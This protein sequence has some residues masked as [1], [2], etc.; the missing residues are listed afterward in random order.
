MSDPSPE[1]SPEELTRFLNLLGKEAAEGEALIPVIHNEMRMIAEACM[2]GE[3]PGGT[4]QATAL[5]NEA[6]LRLF[7]PDRVEWQGRSHFF[8]LAAR[9]M[10][11][12]LVD[13]SRRHRRGGLKRVDAP[14]LGEAITQASN[15]DTDLIDLDA[16]LQELAA[17]DERQEKVVEL[18]YFAGLEV[19]QI[20][21]LMEL[22][23][24]TIEREW[25]SARAWL[26]RRMGVADTE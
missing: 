24:S 13:Q 19:R 6:F 5:V 16:A 1:Q 10:R 18:K 12:L 21:E 4:L 8:A 7:K 3:L 11:R 9:A 20:A 23:V 22:S 26:A 14:T 15:I 17:L 2:R 25:R